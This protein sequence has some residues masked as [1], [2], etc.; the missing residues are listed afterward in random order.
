M[1]PRVTTLLHEVERLDNR[2]LDDFITDVIS[3][4]VRRSHAPVEE[5]KLLEKINKGLPVDHVQ[6]LRVLKMKHE[7]NGLTQQE[8]TE[9]VG[10]VER[11]EK[12]TVSRLKYLIALARLRD[13]PVRE[14]M[15]EL[16]IASNHG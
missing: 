9:L 6:R 15:A 3:L 13:I 4:R 16:G 11:S 10:L 2:A 8:R 5:A 12:C 14:L 7:Q 1:N